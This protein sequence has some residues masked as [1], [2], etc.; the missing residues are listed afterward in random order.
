MCRRRAA[1]TA[2]S[3]Q[4]ALRH[5]RAAGRLAFGMARCRLGQTAARKESGEAIDAGM[6]ANNATGRGLSSV[7][8]LGVAKLRCARNEE[9]SSFFMLQTQAQRWCS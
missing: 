1:A 7:A 5:W 2:S 9:S 4:C 8:R 6:C 3:R